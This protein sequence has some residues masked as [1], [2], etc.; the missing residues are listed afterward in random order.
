M[1]WG[2]EMGKWGGRVNIKKN[3]EMALPLYR[4]V[5]VCKEMHFPLYLVTKC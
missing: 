3:N 1:E 2:K 4:S 5:V